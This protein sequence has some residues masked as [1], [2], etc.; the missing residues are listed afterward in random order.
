MLIMETPL[1]FDKSRQ[2]DTEEHALANG[3]ALICR[4]RSKE[5]L[6]NCKLDALMDLPVK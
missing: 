6:G 4:S 1:I 3:G 5:Y 2:F